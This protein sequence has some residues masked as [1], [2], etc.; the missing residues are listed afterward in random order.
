MT[1]K[2]LLIMLVIVAGISVFVAGC[3]GSEAPAGTD[4]QVKISYDGEWSGAYGDISGQSSIDGV[5]PKTI[6]IP[7][8]KS[9]VSCS[10]QKR[11]SGAGKLVVQ[12]IKNGKVLK[13]QQ[14]SAQ[15]GVVSCS[16]TI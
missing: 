7:N 16:T 14:T 10:F 11:D 3:T 5:G 12:I 13:E 8:A 1:R 2:L 9:V 6:T 4:V 15:Y